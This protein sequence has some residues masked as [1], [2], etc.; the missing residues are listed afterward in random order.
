GISVI[1]KGA[2]VKLFYRGEQS[3]KV[4]VTIYNEKG[5]VVYKEVLEHTDQFMRPYNLSP[6]P[7]GDYVIELRDEQATRTQKITHSGK[8]NRKL[9]AHLRRMNPDENKYM[10]AVPNQ[11]K[12]ELT[13]KIYGQ[14]NTLLYEETEIVDGNFAKLYNLNKVKGDHVFE[15]A[16]KSG[17]VNRLSQPSH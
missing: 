1:Q 7:A 17:R 13:V 5:A 16:D 12:D 3:G 6:L 11:G 14:D 2:V 8:A 15:V 10:L 4:K 9:L